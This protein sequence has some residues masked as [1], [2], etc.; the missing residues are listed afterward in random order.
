MCFLRRASHKKF[1]AANR[2]RA[3][4]TGQRQDPEFGFLEKNAQER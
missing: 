1:M 3:M 4:D 2:R